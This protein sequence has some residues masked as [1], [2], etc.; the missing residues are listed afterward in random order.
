MP[1]VVEFDYTCTEV[2]PNV[3]MPL[4]GGATFVRATLNIIAPTDPPGGM[5]SIFTGRGDNTARKNKPKRVLLWGLT[6]GDRDPVEQL[7]IE[8]EGEKNVV[9]GF[10][11][12]SP[13][14][15]QLSVTWLAATGVCTVN[16]L[17]T[18]QV[19]TNAGKSAPPVSPVTDGM[20]IVGGD[21]PPA[22][23]PA[24]YIPPLTWTFRVR[25]ETDGDI[26]V[27]QILNAQPPSIDPQ[28]P[29]ALPPAPPVVP[30]PPPVPV[31]L[32]Q[33]VAPGGDLLL[34]VLQALERRLAGVEGK[35]GELLA[36]V[37]RLGAGAAGAVGGAP[38]LGAPLGLFGGGVPGLASPVAPAA[39]QDPQAILLQALL[40]QL[41]RPR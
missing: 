4:T 37:Q 25:L 21:M 34:P 19:M 30:L 14:N 6:Q 39:Q 3:R 13:G 18:G 2:Q 31:S 33:P 35:L 12:G 9:A 38:D 16:N 28:P 29:I 11:L 40:A 24:N 20:L 7:K 17:V 26:Q 10:D 8:S 1:K 32:P 27:P 41:T 23:K 36:L 22:G 5:V 15:H